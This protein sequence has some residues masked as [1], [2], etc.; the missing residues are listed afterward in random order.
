M[1]SAELFL[2]TSGLKHILEQIYVGCCREKPDKLG[3]YVVE[4]LSV[5]KRITRIDCSIP[6]LVPH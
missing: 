4:F 1:Q 3:P 5:R 2:D 6:A